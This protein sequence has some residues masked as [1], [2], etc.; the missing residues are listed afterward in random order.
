MKLYTKSGV[1]YADYNDGSAPVR[2]DNVYQGFARAFEKR[3]VEKSL[4]H[5]VSSVTNSVDSL[6]APVTKKV[7]ITIGE[8]VRL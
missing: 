3:G 6:V 7:K 2:C 4:G 1:T 5:K 8:T